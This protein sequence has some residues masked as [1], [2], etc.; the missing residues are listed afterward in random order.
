MFL[1]VLSS[2]VDTYKVE[3]ESPG[4]A[5]DLLTSTFRASCTLPWSRQSRATSNKS[6]HSLPRPRNHGQEAKRWQSR[7]PRTRRWCFPQPNLSSAKMPGIDRDTFQSIA[8]MNKIERMVQSGSADEVEERRL[9]AR[10]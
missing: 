4:E 9:L 8:S 10:P 6:A 5:E 2:A 7:L 1:W 3:L